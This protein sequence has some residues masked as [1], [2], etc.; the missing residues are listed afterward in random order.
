MKCPKC[1]AENAHGMV[2]CG[3]CAE[4]LFGEDRP[5]ETEPRTRA[6]PEPYT[7]YFESTDVRMAVDLGEAEDA[8][9]AVAINLR[10]LFLVVLLS[11]FLMVFTSISSSIVTLLVLNDEYS[12]RSVGTFMTAIMVAALIVVIAGL[13]YIIARKRLTTL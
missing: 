2:R 6:V 11:I 3:N 12:F 1:G 13:W 10:R 5:A 9:V 7:E 4:G 8:L